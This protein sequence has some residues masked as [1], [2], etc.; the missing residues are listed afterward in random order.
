MAILQG[1]EVTIKSGGETLT[2]YDNPDEEEAGT[3]SRKVTRYIEAVPG[4]R[5]SICVKARP[6]F[7]FY[8]ATG[9]K[10]ER[11]MDGHESPSFK[12]FSTQDVTTVGGFE[13][14]S[15][16]FLCAQTGS[17]KQ[18]DF[19][20]G[21][22]EILDVEEPQPDPVKTMQIGTI[23]VHVTRVTKKRR[24]KPKMLRG[25]GTMETRQASEI[26]LKGKDIQT[27]VTYLNER[28]ATTPALTKYIYIPLPTWKGTLMAFRFLYRSRSA[29]QAIGCIPPD[30]GSPIMLQDGLETE[31]SCAPTRDQEESELSAI[32]VKSDTVKSEQHAVKVETEDVLGAVSTPMIQNQSQIQDSNTQGASMTGSIFM[33]QRQAILTELA[34]IEDARIQRLQA[35]LARL[36][37]FEK[38]QNT[39]SSP[40]TQESRAAHT[41]FKNGSTDLGLK[42]EREDKAHIKAEGE[43]KH[44][45][46]RA[47]G[48]AVTIDLTD[49]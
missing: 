16:S 14:G 20:F 22:L 47:S 27:S 32:V 7:Q 35:E 30:P 10:V 11:W 19:G 45:R 46:V 31:S 17:R 15:E 5:F 8:E 49:D 13:Y 36:D 3:G 18:R 39:T 21:R 28:D 24:A 42:R 6:E 26:S 38:Q 9:V 23:S 41:S 43:T 29:L 25:D 12:V 44:K 37:N 48:P 40:M 2:E 1:L 4:S 34:H 33:Q